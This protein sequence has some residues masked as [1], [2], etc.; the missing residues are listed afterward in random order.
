MRAHIKLG[1][2]LLAG[3]PSAAAQTTVSAN[4]DWIVLSTLEGP[5]FVE[6]CDGGL[7]VTTVQLDPC[8]SYI[9]GAV[10]ALQ[11]SGIL[12][13]ESGGYTLK[14]IATVRKFVRDHQE[15]WD[16][17]PVTIVRDALLPHYPCNQD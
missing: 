10:D 12:C 2:A 15:R 11:V 5:A 13:V 16:R 7:A 4:N 9:L 14:A 17:H 3:A 6:L 8:N 1:F